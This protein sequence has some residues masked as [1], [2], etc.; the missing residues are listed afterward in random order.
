MFLVSV[1]QTC[2][3]IVNWSRRSGFGLC[4]IGICLAVMRG[5]Q[6]FRGS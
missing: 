2:L 3:R 5:F 6:S 4:L 1:M